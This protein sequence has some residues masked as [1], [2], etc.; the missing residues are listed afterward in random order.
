MS[1][2]K[3]STGREIAEELLTPGYLDRAR[4]RATR[5]K[6]RWN[7][8]LLPAV[9]LSIG[10]VAFTIVWL[11]DLYLGFRGCPPLFSPDT[12]EW[13]KTIVVCSALFVSLPL[14]MLLGNLLVWL[15]PPARRALN[16]EAEA[17]P[18]TDY[19]T[20]QR[21]LIY[22]SRKMVKLYRRLLGQL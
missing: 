15:I 3:K 9:V 4:Q 10:S 20:S 13:R 22:L 17:H 19:R 8:L 14:G 11:S 12:P 5:R 1:T 7:L 2:Q 18:G 6:S 16:Q 21:H